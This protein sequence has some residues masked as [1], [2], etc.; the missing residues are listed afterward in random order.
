MATT[1]FRPQ[2]SSREQAIVLADRDQHPDPVVRTQMN[3]LWTVHL[4]YSRN[5]AAQIA[6]IGIASMINLTRS[7]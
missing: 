7:A 4:G 5:Q 6:H 3:V 2:L 1:W